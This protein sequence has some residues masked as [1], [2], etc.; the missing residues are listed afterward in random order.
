MTTYKA[1]MT[2]REARALYFAVN[3][4][5]D[6]GGYDD[7][8]VKIWFGPFPIFFPNIPSR[9]S[10]VRFHDLHHILTEYETTLAGEAEIA[11]WEIA[12]GDLPNLAGWFLDLGG[13]NYGLLLYPRRLFRAFVRGRRSLS[14]YKF[15]FSEELLSKKV[16]D[17]RKALY[18]DREVP[19]A[20]LSDGLAFIKCA[21]LSVASSMTVG[22][23][24]W[25]P[26][27]AMGLLSLIIGDRWSGR[28]ISQPSG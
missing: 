26:L 20:K 28:K 15:P 18:L 1:E 14:L 11:A 4:F 8:W 13:F 17:V 16:G 19:G 5:G 12:T 27:I 22:V 24:V 6:D 9:R 25:A 10:A 21:I 23:V 2:L 7:Q 3:D